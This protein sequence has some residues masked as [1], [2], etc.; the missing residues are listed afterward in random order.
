LWQGQYRVALCK[1]WLGKLSENNIPHTE[2]PNLISTLGDPVEIRSWQ[3]SYRKDD[4][5]G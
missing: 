3:A 4:P 5:G 2:E 1:E